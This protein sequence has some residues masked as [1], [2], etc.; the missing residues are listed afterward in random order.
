[1]LKLELEKIYKEYCESDIKELKGED[2]FIDMM[3]MFIEF[4]LNVSGGSESTCTVSM[5][6]TNNFLE[7]IFLYNNMMDDWSG[8]YRGDFCYE[9]L[10]HLIILLNKSN[11]EENIKNELISG[12]KTYYHIN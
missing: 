7:E 12:Y 9:H 1:M 3:Q 8:Q 11:L 2:K 10:D 4:R 6:N 5:T